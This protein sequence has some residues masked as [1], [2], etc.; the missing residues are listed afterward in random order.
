MAEAESRV[1]LSYNDYCKTSD[2]CWELLSGELVTAPS[3]KRSY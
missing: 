2:E 3:P 1:K